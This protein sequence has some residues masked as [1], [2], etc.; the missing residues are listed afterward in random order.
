MIRLT[1]SGLAL[2]LAAGLLHAAPAPIPAS[3]ADVIQARC[4][5]CHSAAVKQADV[6]LEQSAI[7]WDDPAS[8]KLWERVLRAVDQ[9]RMPPAP[10]PAPPAEEKAAVLAFI[11]GGLS[12]HTPFGGDRPR[13]L[14]NAEYEATIQTLFDD[15]D[16]RLPMGFPP[17]TRMHGFDNVAAGLALSPPLMEAY[18]NVAWE[19]AD[20]LYPPPKPAPKKQVWK[21]APEDMVISFSASTLKNGV[22]RLASRSVD[23]M[24]SCTWP[25]RTE[26]MA[27]GRYRITLTASEFKPKSSEPMI[28]EVWAREL[29]A[30]D[31]SKINVFR[32][33]Q[34]LEVKSETPGTFTF[35]ADLYEGQTPLLRWEN[36][37]LDHTMAKLQELY[38]QRFERDPRYLAAYQQALFSKEGKL[39]SPARLRGRNGH[40]VIHRNMEDPALDM[41]HATMDDP[42]TK[43][44]VEKIATVG[45]VQNLGDTLAHEYF[46]NGP[47]LQIHGLTVEGPLAIVD[48]PKDIR[49][50]ERQLSL[51][52]VEKD[53][54]SKEE[55]GRRALANLL[56]RAFRRPVD[57]ATLNGYLKIATDHWAEGHTL[58]EG[59]HLLLRSVLMS[60]RFLYRALEPGKLD[61]YDLATRLS[62]F[63]TKAPPDEQLREAARTG[64]IERPEVL[65]AQAER[66]MPAKPSAPMVRSFTG[67]WLGTDKLA[68][69]MP[70]PSFEF[71]AADT[72]MSRD[73]VE[74]FFTEILTKNL[75]MTDFIDPD[76]AYT[77][78]KFA[79]KYYGYEASGE[80]DA[81]KMA[82]LPIQRGGRY[83]GLLGQAG[84]MMATANGV[85]TQPVLRGVWVL[86]NILG[87]PSPP[88]PNNVPALTP[89]TAGAKTPRE[90]LAAHTKEPSCA[91]CHK[92]ID[93]FGFVLENFD[94]VGRW[95]EEWPKSHTP[96][97]S[98]AT[99]PDGT[100]VR[101]VT[102]LKRWLVANIDSFSACFADK[103]MTYATGRAPNYAEK[104]ELAA[105]VQENRKQGSRARDL[106][107]ALIQ[108]ETFRTR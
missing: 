26:I 94:P 55:Y 67:Q 12:A 104:K 14:S 78:A 66:L 39:Q 21:S 101:D 7:D 18:A 73:E 41:S 31:R 82:R 89:D 27:S 86:D 43:L 37:E 93:P 22:L 5:I 91:V 65:R 64:A 70:D 96:I 35:E 4:L 102:D 47:S 71:S 72:D 54:V 60:P 50:H 97:D 62:Y 2:L 90:L 29:T 19:V 48:G 80:G 81:A 40:D 38:R 108:S 1:V 87:M 8:R 74:A 6:N 45:F 30:S 95:R 99:L 107:L 36:A 17:D 15:P 106:M 52:G 57:E 61:S 28:L 105:I 84:T 56:P 103:L 20:L 32:K 3:A 49:R 16:F 75:P 63:L 98:S 69:I 44:L 83:G 100:K 77:S 34:T 10:I 68:S 13:R 42:W 24:R 46:E 58:D 23:I 79:A 92:R 88:P 59:M 51:A 85:D 11:D 25:S 76:F 33:L 53:A 9:G